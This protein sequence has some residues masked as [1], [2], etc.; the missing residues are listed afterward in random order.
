MF[1]RVEKD[2]IFF[3]RQ[4]TNSVSALSLDVADYRHCILQVATTQSFVGSIFIV[5]AI[6]QARPSFAWTGSSIDATHDDPYDFI[7]VVSLRDGTAVDGNTGIELTTS[8]DTIRLYEVNIN[9]L[10]WL[11]VFVTA[12][13]AGAVSIKATIATNS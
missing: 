10:D 6:G 11:G 8:T 7:E 9:A 3:D 13:K 12:I 4:A 1:R 2:R 5:G